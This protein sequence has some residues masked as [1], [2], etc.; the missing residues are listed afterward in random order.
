M[1][2]NYTECYW[3]P[4]EIPR[5][6]G[7]IEP[8]AARGES[9]H[10]VNYFGP[11]GQLLQLDQLNRPL[12]DADIVGQTVKV[13]QITDISLKKYIVIIRNMQ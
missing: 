6:Q 8:R 9:D 2:H 5:G 1:P 4:S 10:L 11:L 13:G 3:D 7:L 12:Y